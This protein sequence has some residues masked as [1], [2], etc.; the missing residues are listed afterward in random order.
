[1]HTYTNGSEYSFGVE[2]AKTKTSEEP[3]RLTEVKFI[4]YLPTNH[5]HLIEI[6]LVANDFQ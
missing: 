6:E 3:Q 4:K 1:M 2:A 5:Y